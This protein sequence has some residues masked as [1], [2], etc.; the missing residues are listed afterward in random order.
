[1]R[2]HT[3]RY[4]LWASS[5]QA[6]AIA[7]FVEFVASGMSLVYLAALYILN[8]S[9]VVYFSIWLTGVAASRVVLHRRWLWPMGLVLCVASISARVLRLE[10]NFFS[11]AV[12]GSTFAALLCTLPRSREIGPSRGSSLAAR[13]LASF[14][15]TLYVVHVPLIVAVQNNFVGFPELAD[16]TSLLG[17]TVYAAAF[18][19]LLGAAFIISRLT[20]HYTPAVRRA[21]KQMVGLRPNVGQAVAAPS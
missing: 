13:I 14:S 2:R 21:L 3:M 16:P 17:G 8:Y 1:M 11:D 10:H 20:E 18:A 15:F 19:T 9:I 12:V 6:V 7:S 5:L 4:S